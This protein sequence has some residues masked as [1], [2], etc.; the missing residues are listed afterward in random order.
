MS[1][2]WRGC[3]WFGRVICQV[4]SLWRSRVGP[5]SLLGGRAGQSLTSLE[6]IPTPK[7]GEQKA[8]TILGIGPH[9]LRESL[10]SASR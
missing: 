9:K 5:V 8:R 2:C 6:R 1:G 10:R 7:M 4:A 3:G